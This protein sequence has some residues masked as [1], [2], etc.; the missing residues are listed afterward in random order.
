MRVTFLGTGTSQG[1]PIIS[2]PCRV[3]TS[4]DPRDN[5]LR[6]SIMLSDETRNIVIDSGPDFRQQM[7]RAGAKSLDAIVYTHEHKDHIAGMDDIRAFNYFQKKSIPLYCSEQVE[8]ALHREFFYVFS[9]QKYPGVPEAHIERIDL[10]PFAV[11][12]V[13]FIPIDVR[14][15][16]LPVLGFRIGDFTYVTDANFISETEKDK[17]RGSRILVLNALRQATHPSHFTLQEAIALSDELGAQTTYF[18]H[19][20]HQLGRHD[21]ISEQLPSGKHLAWD[22]LEIE[23]QLPKSG[24]E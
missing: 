20:S 15:M 16:H 1:V 6:S 17:I 8:K 19:I 5:R 3:C 22:G 13:P 14:H 7:L 11:N 10:S 2:C 23:I 9:D 12:G 21:E 18:T 24:S 4:V